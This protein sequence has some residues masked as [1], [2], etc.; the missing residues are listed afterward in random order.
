MTHNME[1]LKNFHQQV[2]S[3][4]G[5]VLGSCRRS[6]YQGK[7]GNLLKYP[8]GDQNFYKDAE[9]TLTKLVLDLANLKKN[10]FPAGYTSPHPL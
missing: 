1:Y 9:K 6:G 3:L 5:D 4:H 10:K 8:S 2:L 7:D